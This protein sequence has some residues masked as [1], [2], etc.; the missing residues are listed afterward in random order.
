MIV[1][2]LDGTLLREDKSISAYTKDVI[3][4]CRM[5]GIKLAFATGRGTAFKVAPKELFDGRIT[6]NGA[7]AKAGDVIVY[8]KLIPYQ[9]ARPILMACDKQGLNIVSQAGMH[10]S[11]F[12]VS[13]IWPWLTE[14][15]I[16]DFAEHDK[17]AEKLYTNAPTPETT[18]FINSLLPED[19]YSV[20]TYDITGYLLQIMHKEATKGNAVLT[21][22]RH[23]NIQPSEIVTFGNDLN[24]IDM[25][26]AVDFGVAVE[27]AFD[28]VKA[29]AKYI[30]GSNEENGPAKWISENVLI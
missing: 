3:N 28:E 30:C 5:A 26:A 25:L 13:D 15:K 17:D 1:T 27:N 22:A 29:A 2:D 4:K 19:L 23:W 10:Y 8:N 16:V 11:N 12:K 21:L 9:V 14:F 18:E 6:N 20:A 24:D 7:I